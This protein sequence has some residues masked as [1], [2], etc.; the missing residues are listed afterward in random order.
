LSALQAIGAEARRLGRLTGDLLDLALLET[1]QVRVRPE[2][3]PLGELLAGVGARFGPAAAQA[4]VA[5]T[6]DIVG[7][8]TIV[9]DG[10]RLEQALVNL[11]ANALRHT[12][13][14][15]AITLSA[16]SAGVEAR[17]SVA[18]TGAGIPADELPRI[19]E[20]F[21]RVDK[22]RDRSSG[23][24]GVG[25]GLAI[26]QSAITLLHGRI[27]VESEVGAGTTFTIHLPLRLETPHP[28]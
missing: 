13:A 17:L 16:H 5:L 11:V 12:P 4:G 14:G 10:L 1:G 19:W 2:R 6:L 8:P 7:A 26:C 3:V 24:A 22:G 23:G 27:A 28:A 18:D 21:Y 9:T 20:R 15:G 25:L